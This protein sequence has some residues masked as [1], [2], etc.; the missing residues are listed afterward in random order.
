[1]IRGVSKHLVLGV[2][3][4]FV[5]MQAHAE[6]PVAIVEEVTGSPGVEP[7]DY[8]TPGQSVRL[9]AKDR[10]VLSYIESCW[11]ETITGGT[12]T[13]G[14][15]QSAVEGGTVEREK[16]ACDGGKMELAAAQSKQAAAMVFRGTVHPLPA[17]PQFAIYAR[18]PMIELPGGGPLS[19]ERVDKAGEK[20]ELSLSAADLMHRR[21]Y[22]LAK[23][24][25][26]LQAGGVYRA[27]AGNQQ[28]VFQ[29]DPAAKTDGGPAASRLVRFQPA[30]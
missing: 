4:G 19:I 6:A 12:V 8:V 21:F 23:T 7:M 5:P 1:M 30:H 11:R 14:V 13:I 28:V 26:A 17:K 16:V 9:G 27:K 29:V 22:D 2:A 24:G 20:L 18:C 10:L 25:K 3:F 15:A